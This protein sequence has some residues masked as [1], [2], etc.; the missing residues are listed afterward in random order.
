MSADPAR[1]RAQRGEEAAGGLGAQA[2][3]GQD[4]EVRAAVTA[5]LVT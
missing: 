1:H 4:Q 5:L 3:R 2:V